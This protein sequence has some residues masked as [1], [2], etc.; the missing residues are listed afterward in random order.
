MSIIFED[1]EV[2]TIEGSGSMFKKPVVVA[3]D[4]HV[5][6]NIAVKHGSIIH[7]RVLEEGDRVLIK[8]QRN[9]VE[10][11]IYVVNLDGEPTRAR[12]FSTSMDVRGFIIYET[13]QHTLWIATTSHDSDTVIVGE[14]RIIFKLLSDTQHIDKDNPHKISLE[15][16]RRIDEH[17]YGDVV[18]DKGTIKVRDPEH[19][20][21]VA[22]KQY[23]DDSKLNINNYVLNYRFYYDSM[24]RVYYIRYS[25]GLRK[26]IRYNSINQIVYIV[27]YT[28]DKKIT[29]YF[30]YRDD[31]L[32]YTTTSTTRYRRKKHRD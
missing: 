26:Y 5:S 14:D 1:I 3:S 15:N 12:D 24:G 23:V 7:S 20:N 28:R 9:P 18:F 22:T 16:A 4:K 19:Y 10:N 29:Q 8:N 27:Y 30:H 21:E 31:K 32:L 13:H 17:L 11:G 25:S 6:L 2:A